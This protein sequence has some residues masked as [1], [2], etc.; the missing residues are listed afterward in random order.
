MSLFFDHLAIQVEGSNLENTIKWYVDFFECKRN[1]QQSS[2]FQQLTLDR[3]PG[4]QTIVELESS[5]FRFHLFSKAIISKVVYDN[6]QYHHI[7]FA[8]KSSDILD[9]LRAKWIRLQES[10][11]YNFS[12]NTYVTEKIIDSLGVESLYF[13]DVNG[14]EYELTFIPA[15]YKTTRIYSNENK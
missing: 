9:R 5:Y 1:W 11:Q 2:N 14:L 4:I 13:T 15:K 12:E 8:A 7:G 6:I 10:K 3:I